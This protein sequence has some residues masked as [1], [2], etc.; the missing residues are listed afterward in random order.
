MIVDLLGALVKDRDRNAP[1]RKRKTAGGP[2]ALGR[3][4][5]DPTSVIAARNNR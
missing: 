1:P 5:V 3:Q 4:P 2:I